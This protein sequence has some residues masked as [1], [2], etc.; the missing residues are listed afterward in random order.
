MKEGR[1][2]LESLGYRIAFRRQGWSE[3]LVW[4]E[5]ERWLGQGGDENQ[6]LE[7]VLEQ[8]FPSEAARQL[9]RMYAQQ[10]SGASE[11]KAESMA[12]P[13]I[14]R[15]PN[16]VYSR[17][18]ALE[19][20]TLLSDRIDVERPEL[21]L[22]SPI[23][24][25]MVMLA[26]ICRA[27]TWED[28]RPGD[29]FVARQVAGIA[30]KITLLGKIWWPG[31][32]RSL[33]VN[34]T[35]TDAVAEAGMDGTWPPRNWSDAAALLD[36]RLRQLF[37]HD[38]TVGRDD[39]GWMDAEALS[40]GPSD[41]QR[42][43]EEIASNLAAAAGSLTEPARSASRGGYTPRPG[44]Q[45]RFTSWARQLRWIRGS[46][47]DFETWGAAMGRLRWLALQGDSRSSALGELLDP[48]YRP[49][50]PWAEHQATPVASIETM[51]GTNPL[52]VTVR[53]QTEGMRALLV[54]GNESSSV[55][56]N[57][58]L[59]TD[60]EETFGLAVSTKLVDEE[61]LQAVLPGLEKGDFDLL[62]LR[63]R[64]GDFAADARLATAARRAKIPYVRVYRSRP[65]ATARALA[66]QMGLK[67]AG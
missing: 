24:Q 7:V 35:P 63:T 59:R 39:Y 8:M 46:A 66:Q 67:A 19:A 17:A 4:R 45:A 52:I 47:S 51:P 30:R 40:P 21:A 62:V 13:P 18:E 38:E 43:L 1:R 56:A 5:G 29:S 27:R 28:R 36:E 16:R 11:Q 15:E 41:P 50:G 48:D 34:S 55:A 23:R 42:M 44:D 57:D 49:P 12:G 53:G 14:P 58:E 9:M 25:R 32:V 6:A 64:F 2:I 37:A 3:C 26:W 61:T 10:S 31:S 22:M 65:L 20:L 54:S 60:L 33:H